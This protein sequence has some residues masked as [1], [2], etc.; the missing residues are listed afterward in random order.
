MP[1]AEETAMLVAVLFKRAALKRARISNLTI[2]R[3]SNRR[4]IRTAFLRSLIDHLDDRG[5]ILVELERGGYGLIPSSSLDGAPAITAKKYLPAE[6]KRDFDAT[7]LSKVRKELEAETAF[8]N[9][10]EE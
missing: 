1:N 9:A 10:D 2:R 7:A 4:S 3:L 5:L 6:L 8:S